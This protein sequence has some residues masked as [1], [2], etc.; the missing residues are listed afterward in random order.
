MRERQGMGEKALPLSCRSGNRA[1]QRKEQQEESIVPPRPHAPMPPC[2]SLLALLLVLLAATETSSQPYYPRPRKVEMIPNSHFNRVE[3]IFLG[4]GMRIRPTSFPAISEIEIKGGYGFSN[5]RWGYECSVQRIWE[6]AWGRSLGTGVYGLVDT[7]DRWRVEDEESSLLALL[8]GVSSRDYLHQSGYSVEAV[9]HLGGLGTLTLRYTN[10][11]HEAVRKRTDWCLYDRK[12]KKRANWEMDDAVA[13]IGE[14]RSNSAELSYLLR[15]GAEPWSE[16][17]FRL[18]VSAEYGGDRLKGD[19]SFQR[20][21][22]EAEREYGGQQKPAVLLSGK[23]GLLKGGFPLQEG[24]HLGGIGT[25]PGYEYKT[26]SGDRMV[27]LRI[28]YRIP[29]D[30]VDLIPFANGGYAWPKGRALDLGDLK[31]DAG[32]GLRAS[33][34]SSGVALNAVRPIGVKGPKWK[35]EVRFERALR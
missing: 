12:R 15:T 35:W 34:P 9:Q 4:T 27:L 24:F 19:F 21:W 28:A 6:G 3:G 10:E 25:L 2:R 30:R 11:E 18:L 29:R 16:T 26:F 23:A 7:P 31:W 33:G 32:V 13:E 22:I 5:R 20:Y 17:A 14:G 8:L 1:D